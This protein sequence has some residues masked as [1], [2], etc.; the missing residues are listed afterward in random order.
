M[1]SGKSSTGKALAAL[2]GWEHI[3]LDSYIE[4]KIGLDP[5]GIISRDGEVRFRAIEAEALRDV[6][7]MHQLTGE[8]LILSL[9]GGTVMTTSVRHLIFGQTKCVYLKTSGEELRRRR[10]D[11]RWPAE[12]VSVYEQ[13]PVT[14]DTDGK[15]PQEVAELIRPRLLNTDKNE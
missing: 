2:L 1:G 13:A 14:V 4:A 3:D 7:T 12:R 8:N 5:E 15:T 10:A 9:G 11:G 6:V